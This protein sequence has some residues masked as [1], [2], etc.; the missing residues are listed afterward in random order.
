MVLLTKLLKSI[1]LFKNWLERK[2]RNMQ[3]HKLHVIFV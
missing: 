2:N 3:I 1:I